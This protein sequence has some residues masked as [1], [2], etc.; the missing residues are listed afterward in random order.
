M[1][2]ILL[3]PGLLTEI[4]EAFIQFW[5]CIRDYTNRKWWDDITQPCA[6]FIGGL[7]KISAEVMAGMSNY[8]IHKL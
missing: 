1:D 6:N 3:K 7:S 4:N 5:L 8:I 2:V